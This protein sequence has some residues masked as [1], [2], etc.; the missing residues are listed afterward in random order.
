M[1]PQPCDGEQRR[2]AAAAASTITAPSYR[3]AGSKWLP[4]TSTGLAVVRVERADVAVASKPGH[5][6]Q[7]LETHV[8]RRPK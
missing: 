1:C 4:T 7:M 6:A 8:Q 5:S 3:V 2:V